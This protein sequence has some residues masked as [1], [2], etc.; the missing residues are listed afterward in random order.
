MVRSIRF[1][2]KQVDLKL[3]IFVPSL[4]IFR[5]FAAAAVAAHTAERR[6][7]NCFTSSEIVPSV[8]ILATDV[9]QRHPKGIQKQFGVGGFPSFQGFSG[10]N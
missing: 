1:I 4:A 7:F 5:I 3:D 6:G 9:R 8:F 10:L 2:D